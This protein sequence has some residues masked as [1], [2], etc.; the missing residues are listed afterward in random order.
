MEEQ[1]S[2]TARDFAFSPVV[3]Y[4]EVTRACDLDCRNCRACAQINR[5]PNE[6]TPS[7][8]RTL[9]DQFASFPKPPTLILTGG[10]PMK[11]PDIYD[12]ARHAASIGLRTTMTVAATALMSSY[13]VDHLMSCGIRRLTMGIDGADEETHDAFRGV[14]GSFSKTLQILKVAHA[15]GMP[16]EVNTTVA[17]HN[18][19]QI[20]EIA[21]TI[22]EFGISRWSLVF[23]V[24]VG[25]GA[26][27]AS[28]FS[29][30]I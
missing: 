4:Y 1:R 28:D 27:R 29:V 2:Y 15:I 8:S 17:R 24:P 3:A 12:L 13:A 18:V 21:D 5:H 14:D 30:R 16:T 9:L 11:R 22:A 19:D 23:P 26:R 25:R 10:D 20:D 6:L 7:Q